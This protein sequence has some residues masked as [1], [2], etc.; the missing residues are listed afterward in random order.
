MN[1]TQEILTGIEVIQ[2]IGELPQHVHTIHFDSRKVEQGDVFVAVRGTQTDGHNYIPSVE[3]AGAALIICEELPEK[4]NTH[5]CF[6]QVANSAHALGLMASNLFDNPSKKLKLIGITGTNGKTS[7][8]TMLY[9]LHR[10]LGYACGL[11]STVQNII[12]D[13][14]S[15]ATHTTG[16]AIQLNSLMHQMVEEGCEYC[17]MEVSSHALAQYRTSG[18]E[19]SGALFSNITHDHLDYHGSFKNYIA[20]KKMLF[21]GLSKE[22]FA[23]V[24][25]DDKN[26]RVML[27]NCKAKK[28][29]YSVQSVADYEARILENTFEGLQLRLNGQELWVPLV[30]RF[31]VYNL[32]AVYGAAMELGHDSLEVM[33]FLSTIKS[34][35]G[36]FESIRSQ[37]GITAIVDYAHTP[38]ALK[39]VLSTIND[40]RNGNE[41]LITVVG[42][43]GN[44]DKS[45]RPIMAAIAAD[46]ST[47]VI[48]TSDNPR[49]ENPEDI[50]HDMEQGLDPVQKKHTLTISNRK[51][52]IKAACMWAQEGDIILVAGKGHEK[53]QEIKGVRHH[54]DD[55]EIVNEFLNKQ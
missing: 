47:R 51:E 13:K 54:F 53:Y 41:Q 7:T 23:L 11:L 36:R 18:L 38:D 49:N 33:S 45:K 15:T 19:F 20:A 42:T 32:L 28:L 43:G 6:I 26:G 29:S 35:E 52:A 5:T 4:P 37:S 50:L 25:N 8:V 16:D 1:V 12:N 21:D 44:R 27:Q 17:F 34:A 48:L 46:M 14:V 22:A 40:I 9:N 31:N 39:N 24:N 55:K 3:E 2:Q 10:S 30:G